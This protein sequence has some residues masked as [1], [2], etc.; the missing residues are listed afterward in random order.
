[1]GERQAL[2]TYDRM[3]ALTELTADITLPLPRPCPFD[4]PA[5]YGRLRSERP[6]SKVR[7][8]GG[9][10][11]WLA[12]RY[13]DVRA[14]LTDPR[15]SSDRFHP[16][17]P[18]MLEKPPPAPK[19]EM[20]SLINLDAPEHTAARRAVAGEFT[21]RRVQALRPR[22]QQIVD[23]CLDAM[24]AAGPPADLVQVLSLPVP[25]RVIC[26]LIG[27]PYTDHEFFQTRTA[28]FAN[29]NTSA[30]NRMRTQRELLAYLDAL[31]S[32]KEREPGDDLLG[33]QARQRRAAGE[34]D[35]AYLVGLAFLLLIAGHE[36]TANMITLGILA[37]MRDPSLLG[38]VS[39]QPDTLALTVDE[40]LRY[41]TVVDLVT[42]RVALTDAEIGG[43][44]IKAGEG[45]IAS[46]LAANRDPAAFAEPDA[47]D[48]ARGARH[49]VAFG[50]GPHQCLGQHLAKTELEIV[51]ETVFRRIP[52][53]RAAAPADRLPV[54]NDAF[55]YGLYELP[56]TW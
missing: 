13:E 30:A 32:E 54:K 15:F 4:P 20:A 48:T 36:T 2:V 21:V 6:L 42:S 18:G 19:R 33:R 51:Y 16:S 46:A 35:H 8:P 40:L 28:R 47:L 45:V 25:S 29:R 37:M 5:E 39:G 1:M 27:V 56:V 22:I 43:T 31:V 52:G 12:T 53:L 3:T 17:F 7:L 44:P 11:A 38:S 34:R 24:L 26:E 55:I 9:R 49:H 50:F 14:I 23:D 10:E 41:F